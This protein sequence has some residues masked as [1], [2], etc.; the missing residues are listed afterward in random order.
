MALQVQSGSDASTAWSYAIRALIMLIFAGLV[1]CISIP[2][3][4]RL[5]DYR[6]LD[7]EARGYEDQRLALQ[8]SYEHRSAELALLERDAAFIEIKARDHLDLCRPDEVIFQF[9]DAGR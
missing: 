4:S 3:R 5:A 1:A 6:A 8:R 7:S 2:F 9:Q